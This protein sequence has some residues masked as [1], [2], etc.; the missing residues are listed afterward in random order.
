M[1]HY[2]RSKKKG[3]LKRVASEEAQDSFSRKN[4]RYDD[5][6]EFGDFDHE[7]QIDSTF[8]VGKPETVDQYEEEEGSE[9][10]EEEES[11]EEEEEFEEEEEE[12]GEEE[13]KFEEE[14]EEFEEEEEESGEEEGKFEEE[15]EEFEEEEEDSGEE[16]EEFEEEEEEFEEEEE[17][18]GEEEE[19]FE[20]EEEEEGSEEDDDNYH[21]NTS[22]QNHLPFDFYKQHPF[23]L[24]SLAFLGFYAADGINSAEGNLTRVELQSI[25]F[26]FLH[27]ILINCGVL[28]PQLK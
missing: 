10:E 8:N 11:G 2:T 20:E 12:S 18:S 21:T 15:E 16:E 4:P 5:G 22:E 3:V 17:D 14:E 1:A 26:P 27:G 13:E 28:R 7:A 23:S 6:D 19:E 25:D 24:S 9:E